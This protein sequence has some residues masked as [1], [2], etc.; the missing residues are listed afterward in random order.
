MF[1]RPANA[2]AFRSHVLLSCEPSGCACP[3]AC[4]L[5]LAST[6]TFPRHSHFDWTVPPPSFG[7]MRYWA[8]WKGTHITATGG[9]R[10]GR[11]GHW[12]SGLGGGDRPIMPSLERPD[13][14]RHHPRPRTGDPMPT[15][16]SL[17][18]VPPLL[19]S[20]PP[21]SP[22]ACQPPIAPPPGSQSSG[23]GCPM[24]TRSPMSPECLVACD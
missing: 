6:S 12:G 18:R 16:V 9:L 4:F 10:A 23:F 8:S 5:S 21:R 3:Y 2:P 22:A 11:L 1:G 20:Q 13:V 24:Q 17:N 15:R 7:I 19:P 14:T